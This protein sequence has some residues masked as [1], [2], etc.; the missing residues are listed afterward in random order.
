[1]AMD[2]QTRNVGTTSVV[3]CESSQEMPGI[4]FSSSNPDLQAV[5][6][7]IFARLRAEPHWCQ[8]DVDGAG[9]APYVE[10]QSGAGWEG[11]NALIF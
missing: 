9:Y 3:S 6:Q 4:P 2:V 10:Y 5:R 7:I 1:M 8:V 11:R